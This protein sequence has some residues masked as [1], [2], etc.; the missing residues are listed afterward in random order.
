MHDLHAH[1]YILFGEYTQSS[2]CA[3]RRR[4]PP[5]A[6][7]HNWRCA[8]AITHLLQREREREEI[9]IYVQEREAERRVN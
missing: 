2:S 3:S 8:F 7:M 6:P 1:K 4:R 9:L 5:F